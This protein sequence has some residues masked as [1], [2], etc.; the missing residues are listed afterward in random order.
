VSFALRHGLSRSWSRLSRRHLKP[1]EDRSPW[2]WL[3]DR[4]RGN[5]R[6][7]SLADCRDLQPHDRVRA[8]GRSTSR[9][10][11]TAPRPQRIPLARRKA[12]GTIAQRLRAELADEHERA[13]AWNGSCATT[14]GVPAASLR[15]RRARGL[16][17]GRGSARLEHRPPRRA[18]GGQ[19]PRCA[20][21]SRTPARHSHA[22]LTR[23]PLLI[24]LPDGRATRR[25][26]RPPS[27]RVY[28]GFAWPAGAPTL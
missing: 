18:L 15:A 9:S 24:A 7:S 14:T 8:S 13:T 19:P 22:G 12:L 23:H 20:E 2:S 27:A 16:A 28:A 4:L 6:S 21:A 1:A 25:Q 11:R 5:P 3:A 17:R 10:A 26:W